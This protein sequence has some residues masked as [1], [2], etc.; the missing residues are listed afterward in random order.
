MRMLIDGYLPGCEFVNAHRIDINASPEVV[1]AALPDTPSVLAPKGII[2]LPLWLSALARFELSGPRAET[3]TERFVI[4]EGEPISIATDPSHHA[5]TI[6]KVDPDANSSHGATTGT[7]T[8]SQTRTSSP[9]AMT[10]AGYTTSRGRTSLGRRSA[11]R[12]SQPCAC[13]TIRLWSGV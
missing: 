11:A 13:S 12:T 1:W 9:E 6:D 3:L 8:T 2:A 5:V 7:P 4:R 10:L